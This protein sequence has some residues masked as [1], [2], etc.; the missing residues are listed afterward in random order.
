MKG[1]QPITRLDI[2]ILGNLFDYPL[3]EKEDYE[4]ISPGLKIHNVSGQD[5]V[6]VEYSRLCLININCHYP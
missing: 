4:D 1:I 2:H 5:F 6:V 3:S